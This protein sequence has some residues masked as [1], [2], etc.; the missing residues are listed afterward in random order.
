MSVTADDA[1]DEF[2]LA[3]VWHGSLERS[4]AIL[5]AHPEIAARDIHVAA[6]LGDDA[7][8]SRFIA[9]DPAVATSRSGPRGWDPLTY[10][11]FSKYLRLDPSRSDAFVR[12]ARTLL[13]AGASART[14][15]WEPDHEP[16]PEWESVMYGAAGVA[17][18]PEL[19]Q[20]LLDYG[21]DPN[22][23]E[24][25]YHAP[26]TYDN[27]ALEVLV[28][29]GRLT[30]E[31]LTMILLRKTDWHDHDGITWLLDRG[32][33]PDRMTRFGKTALHNAL[34]SDNGLPIIETLLDHGAN[35]L[36]GL[37]CDERIRTGAA[38][39]TAVSLAAW[40]GRGDVL[41]LFDSR[42]IPLALDGAERL[43]AA[44]AR[45]DDE[46]VRSIASAEPRLVD[47]VIAEGGTLLAQ[48]AGNGNT[49]GV[50]HLL[51][52]GV[53]V[54]ARY[55]Q[56]NSY[57]GIVPNSTALHAAA[58]LA[59]HDTVARLVERGAAIDMAD[60]KGRTPLML[61]VSACV[62]SYWTRR[63]SP[64]SVAAL[65]NAGASVDGVMFP[66][67]YA[68]VDALLAA[69]GSRSGSESKADPRW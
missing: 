19:T 15:F 29:S 56:G 54:N 63:R 47:E 12:A 55:V 38:G 14:G 30:D 57:L 7:A 33:D 41:D 36:L 66:S 39:Q 17:H 6:V 68:E 44:C 22:D 52:L 31:S 3:S 2:L 13:E 10:L 58:W 27:R 26:E 62:D 16:E 9:G 65:L 34:L 25:P 20:L 4:Q 24:T 37:A 35:P 42:G 48:F 21:A 5:A 11:C 60:G 59:R 8:V 43:I 64:A 46:R 18:H 49:A 45:D 1:R 32:I 51:D 28:R 40:R 67:G 69:H 53:D 50:R 23:E 61:A